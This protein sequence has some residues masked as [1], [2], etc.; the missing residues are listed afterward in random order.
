MNYEQWIT[1]FLGLVVVF[2]NTLLFASVYGMAL[3]SQ[4]IDWGES[5]DV[6]VSKSMALLGTDSP[7]ISVVMLYSAVIVGLVCLRQDLLFPALPF[8]YGIA[9]CFFALLPIVTTDVNLEAHVGLT[10]CFFIF[11][12][13]GIIIATRVFH[14][15][16]KST[17]LILMYIIDT[18]AGLGIFAAFSAVMFG[19]ARKDLMPIASVWFTISEFLV[20][21]SVVSF[22]F[23]ISLPISSLVRIK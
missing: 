7:S 10:V 6:S 2:T 14:K 22:V 21:I 4:K 3:E 13:I 15:R 11:F 19:L 20:A 5:T 23:V 8:I 1:L 9:S 17:S 12:V 16:N 18:I